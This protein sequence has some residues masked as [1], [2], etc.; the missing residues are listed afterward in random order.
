MDRITF[1]CGLGVPAVVASLPAV[2][3]ADSAQNTSN[4]NI[5]L[6]IDNIQA[7]IKDLNGDESDYGGF[8]HKAVE[9]LQSAIS[10]LQQ[11]LSRVG[12]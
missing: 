5:S 11:A 2:A 1:L 4:R 6:M 12:G 10:N 9:N 7:I 8:K 3:V